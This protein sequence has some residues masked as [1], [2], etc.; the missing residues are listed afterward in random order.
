MNQWKYLHL[1][2]KYVFIVIKIHLNQFI[3]PRINDNCQ[4]F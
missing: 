2:L 3:L 4:L 1:D